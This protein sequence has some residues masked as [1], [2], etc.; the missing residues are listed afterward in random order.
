MA[1]SNIVENHTIPVADNA[2]NVS[3]ASFRKPSFSEVFFEQTPEGV[4]FI[5]ANHTIMSAN[6]AFIRLFGK[7]N[8]DLNGHSVIDVIAEPQEAPTLQSELACCFTGEIINTRRWVTLPSG[9]ALYVE[10]TMTPYTED[11]DPIRWVM[12]TLRDMMEFQRMKQLAKEAGERF[13]QAIDAFNGS[14]ALFDEHERLIVFNQT[15][16]QIHSF[17]GEHLEVG[18]TF[19]KCLRIQLEQGI[20]P[21]AVGREEA[22]LQQRIARF[23]NPQ[24]SFEVKKEPDR[25]YQITET[26]LPNGGCLKTMVDVS[27]LKN[28]E[29]ALHRSEQQFRDFAETAADWFWEMGP[30]LHITYLSERY[31]ELTGNIPNNTVGCSYWEVCA[32]RLPDPDHQ[33]QFCHALENR[34]AFDGLEIEYIHENHQNRY[35]VLSG[36][37]FYDDKNQFAGFRGAGRDITQAK[38][39]GNQLNYQA[40]HDELTGLLN[41]REFEQRLQQALSAAQTHQ[42]TAVL[43]YIDLDQFKIVNDTV[44]HLAGDQMLQQIAQLI[45]RHIRR[46]DTL[47]RL[48]GDE[49]GL[50]LERCSL[51]DATRITE[52]LVNVLQAFRFSWGHRVFE[53]SASIGLVAITDTARSTSE[54]MAQADIACYTA[55][56]LGRGRVHQH[57]EKDAELKKRHTEL[58]RVAGIKQ[59]LEEN[60]FCLYM[61]PIAVLASQ[62]LTIHHY[63]FLLRMRDE[64]GVLLPPGAFIPAA[65][66]YGLMGSI[67]RW[68]IQ[69]ALAQV[70]RVFAHRPELGVTINLSGNSLTDDSL[71]AFV[72]QQLEQSGVS[73]GRVCFE[74][75]ET[76]VISNLTRAQTFISDM[77]SLGCLFALDDFGSGLSSFTYLKHFPVDYLKI[78][79]S[80]VRDIVNDPTDHAM[81]AAINQVGH[82]LGV[83]TIAEFVE[84]DAIMDSLKTMNVDYVQGYGIGRPV[85]L[86]PGCH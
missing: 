67:D 3:Y 69:H 37:P 43:G 35:F 86:P 60:R 53:T 30:D 58:L 49:F 63:E 56:D 52:D 29:I 6:P 45:T 57:S 34:L 75:T 1:T 79:G 70:N 46:N 25:W 73:P 7:S 14:F 27:E 16:R 66:R 36:R 13:S 51:A 68:V 9:M 39:L 81:V 59:A 64:D 22:W 5:D 72:Q 80:F 41:R 77:K 20:I 31:Q 74:I 62:E 47:A 50:L 65:E 21:E 78:D 17:L 40:R 84:S 38:R 82:V 26:R 55:K 54:L 71:S 44:G 18:L 76:A 32:N 61:Q 11:R 83:K 15:Y 33:R 4:V 8:T 2:P 23:R 10:L 12:L 48:G 24:G 85:P 28:A 42:Q 19:E